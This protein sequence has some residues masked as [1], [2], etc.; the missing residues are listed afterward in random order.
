[1][2]LI[3]GMSGATGAIYG[4]RLLEVLAKIPDVK[5]HLVISDAAKRTI[6]H[7]TNWTVA[8]VE[9]LTPYIYDN[10]D[11]GARI[12]SGSFQ[13]L[14]M[15]V[16]PCSMKTMS[17][18]G[19]SYNANLLT[20]AADVTLKERRRLVLVVRETP[21]HSGHLRQMAELSDR[22]VIILPPMPAFYCLPD[23][24]GDIVDQTVGKILDQFHI[25]HKLF[26]R[27]EGISA[28]STD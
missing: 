11:I 23:T 9:A 15:V 13:T 16:I 25:E 14:G 5:A 2:N 28:I 24:I 8:Q 19:I 22:G 10:Q 27:W 26:D 1:M 20:R 21:L 3:V 7:E 12:S 18:I 17:S 4:I 6:E